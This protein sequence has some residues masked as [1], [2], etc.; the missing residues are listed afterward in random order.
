MNATVT[1][2]R[3]AL[4]VSN[5]LLAGIGAVL[6]ILY[7][8]GLHSRGVTDIG[9]FI[10]LALAQSIL[11]LIVVWL[12]VRARGARSTLLIVLLFAGIFRLSIV[13]APPY[14]SDDIYR[15]VW[16]GRVQAAGINPYR[17]IPA[18]EHLQSL[19]DEQ[20]YPKINRRDYAHT[21]YPPGAE[22]VYF[23]T[24]RISE[25]VTWMKLTIV[26]F[27]LIAVW[28]LME[29]LASFGMPRQRVLIYAWHP[30][31]VWEFAGSGHVDPLAFA[32][33]ALALLARRR[34]W[35]TATGVAL[36]LATLAKLFP[37]VLFPALYKRWSWKMPVALVVTIVA[38]YLPYIGVGLPGVI[39]F[40]PGYAQERGIVSGEQ[41]FILGLADRLLGGVKLPNAI[42][43]LFA[44]AV[45]L[46]LALW[47]VFKREDDRLGYMKRGLVLGTAFMVL[48]TPHFPWYFSWLILFLCFVRSI[49]VFYL[50][51]A[52]FVLYGTWMGE[53]PEWV[54]AL[55]SFLYIPCALIGAIAFWNRKKEGA[56]M[57]AQT[58]A[59]DTT[60]SHPDVSSENDYSPTAGLKTERDLT[61]CLS[62]VTVIIAALNEEEAIGEVVRAVPRDIAGE[63]IVVDNGS[64]DRTAEKAGAAGARVITETRR[65]YGSAFRAGLKAL[66]SDCEVVVFLDGDG[67]DFPEKLG[68]LVEPILNGTH[69]FVLGSRILGRREPGS[70]IF[71]QVFAGCLIGFL[72]RVRYGVHYTD[73]G[74]FRAIRRDALEDLGMREET[75]GWPLEMQM[76]AARAGLRILEVPIDYRRRAGGSSKIS[77]TLKGSFLAA[78]CI[79]LTLSRIAISRNQRE[80]IDE[81]T[82]KTRR[83]FRVWFM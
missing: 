6:L 17:Y 11:Y 4:I 29:L 54:F 35:E 62:K 3:N 71:H 38:G 24:T 37:I 41:F 18:D 80:T 82:R 28:I 61:R 8:I 14:L 69:D 44:G 59:T 70:M 33:I 51:T 50:T 66:S 63:I 21:M 9:W 72:I 49:P 2:R 53:Q 30:L 5:V 81:I 42:F 27:E 13:F 79:L 68:A 23:L 83:T 48:F 47:S 25:S 43:L 12:I 16:D 7:R 34:N 22:F 75:Y 1:R 32:F 74:P 52:S 58:Q 15:Y 77:G 60:A 10:K 40:I 39:G 65:G 46:A 31:A 19:R 76:R 55:N 20:I 78:T 26:G 45:L 73:M 36:G 56:T 67:S 64:A 57:L